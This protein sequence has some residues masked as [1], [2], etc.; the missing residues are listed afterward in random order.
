[1]LER[2]P[3]QVKQILVTGG[4]GFIGSNFID[5]VLE[6]NHGV[7][8]VCLDSLSYAGNVVNLESAVKHPNFAFVKA[9]LC[10]GDGLGSA[11]DP[12]DFDWVF[13]FAAET[14]VD[15]SIHEPKI[16]VMTNV[17][18]TLNLLEYF[19][20]HWLNE[21]QCHKRLVHIS[22]DEV[23]GS[24]QDG[25]F[26]ETSRYKPSSPYSASKAGSDHL[27]TA[28]FTTF[29]LPTLTTW[30]TNNYGPRQHPEKLIPLMTIHALEGKPLPVYGDGLQ[31]R[32]WLH[33][34]DHAAGVWQTALRGKVGEGYCFS[35]GLESTVTNLDVVNQI[36]GA[37]SAHLKVEKSELDG[38][39]THVEDRLGHDR[40]YALDS[41]KAAAEL[42]WT[43]K[44]PFQSG[45]AK[46][47]EWYLNNPEWMRE[48][49]GT[50]YKDWLSRNY[51][52]PKGGHQ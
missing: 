13:H 31:V 42:G 5:L 39:I 16:T 24:I 37:V 2:A 32:D 3:S 1:M 30:C 38:L 43:P 22:T 52:Q 51:S 14:H 35:G 44:V 49:Q 15:R 21:D 47:V 7:S 28:Y 10:D 46:T 48:V 26:S 50:D 27:V 8:V 33:V 4:A 41:R 45:F 12:F 25:L 23:Y 18:G 11:L 36:L 34:H 17:I 19:R 40:R 20:G 6:S 9:D 29:G